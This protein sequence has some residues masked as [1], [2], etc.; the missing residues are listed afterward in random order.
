MTPIA[1]YKGYSAGQYSYQNF[2]S[3]G[4]KLSVPLDWNQSQKPQ[5]I[6]E[7]AQYLSPVQNQLDS[8]RENF[9]ISHG[10]YVNNV[11]AP[12]VSSAKLTV[13]KGLGHFQLVERDDRFK[14]D[15]IPASKLVYSFSENRNEYMAMQAILTMGSS[16]LAFTYT[17]ELGK[18]AEYLPTIVKIL[19]SMKIDPEPLTRP[20]TFISLDDK[21]NGIIFKYPSNWTEASKSYLSSIFTIYAPLDHLGDV[22]FDNVRIY[23]DTLKPNST[24]LTAEDHLKEIVNSFK[25][26]LKNFTVLQTQNLNLTGIPSYSI[27]Y[28]FNDTGGTAHQIQWISSIKEDKVYDIIYDSTKST[29]NL[30]SPV[31]Q[32]MMSSFKFKGSNPM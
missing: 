24:N 8:F 5:S 31:L 9:A 18:Y 19:N 14:I 28:S 15:G 2:S 22:Y 21:E 25:N 13:L 32:E 23:A 27:T 1:L 20:I 11:T 26:T 10:R 4:L 17:A 6:D 30:Y 3:A 12:E 7:I 16:Y 29:F